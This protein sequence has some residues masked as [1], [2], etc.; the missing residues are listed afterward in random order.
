MYPNDMLRFDHIFCKRKKEKEKQFTLYGSSLNPG[1]IL[2]FSP[3][4]ELFGQI[5]FKVY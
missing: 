1:I 5:Y 4:V 3:S 2:D